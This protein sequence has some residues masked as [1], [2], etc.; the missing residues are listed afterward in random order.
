MRHKQESF[1][2]VKS[3][4]FSLS[5]QIIEQDHTSISGIIY[6]STFIPNKAQSASSISVN[7]ERGKCSTGHFFFLPCNS[8][9][10]NT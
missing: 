1:R 8:M 10:T 9:Q 3:K 5:V 2:P 4:V 7:S 6:G